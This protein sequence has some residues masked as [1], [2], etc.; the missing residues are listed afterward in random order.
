MRNG[1][2]RSAPRMF[3]PYITPFPFL[4]LP[5]SSTDHLFPYILFHSSSHAKKVSLSHLYPS[6]HTVL[7]HLSSS[8]FW[9][10]PPCH[11]RVFRLIHSALPQF[12]LKFHSSPFP[13]FHVYTS[14]LLYPSTCLK[15]AVTLRKVSCTIL[16]L[17]SHSSPAVHISQ[18]CLSTVNKIVS[19]RFL[20]SIWLS[21][22][23][24]TL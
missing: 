21:L 11:L 24:G 4:P 18:P 6:L 9:I 3:C 23:F 8:T 1:C 5:T 12:T 13:S 19:Q 7:S 15:P 16:I 14:L 17:T 20:I 10:L 2:S 22:F